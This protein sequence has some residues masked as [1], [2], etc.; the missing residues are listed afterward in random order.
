MG[1]NYH[2]PL[3]DGPVPD[4]GADLPDNAGGLIAHDMGRRRRGATGPV[5]D[6][7]TFDADRPYVD[8]DAPRVTGRVRQLLVAEYVRAAG[9][10][11]DC[12]L[13]SALLTLDG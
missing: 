6:V 13:Y 12:R 7:P 10:V 3:A 5:E 2:H 4:L 11:V 1:G 9:L 8:Q